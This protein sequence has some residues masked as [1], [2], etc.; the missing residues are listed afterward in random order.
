M[1][2]DGWGRDWGKGR[3]G[4]RVQVMEGEMLLPGNS[5]HTEDHRKQDREREEGGVL[6]L[7]ESPPEGTER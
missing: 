7:A 6:I 5:I 1:Q 3:E 4:G 2:R